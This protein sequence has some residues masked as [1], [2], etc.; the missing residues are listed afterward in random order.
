MT[1]AI[2][3][4]TA[5]PLMLSTRPAVMVWGIHFLFE[6]TLRFEISPGPLF[7]WMPIENFQKSGR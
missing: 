5:D 6:A 3:V 1:A 7:T 2:R 4:H